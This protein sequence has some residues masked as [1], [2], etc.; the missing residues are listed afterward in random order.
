MPC[1]CVGKPV[2]T[3]QGLGREGIGSDCGV[4]PFDLLEPAAHLLHVGRI[5]VS[6]WRSG[7]WVRDQGGE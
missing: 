1:D 6:I 7:G 3:R 2:A 4:F 5:V